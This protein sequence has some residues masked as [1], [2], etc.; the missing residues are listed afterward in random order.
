MLDGTGIMQGM[1]VT[2]LLRL[3]DRTGTGESR[4]RRAHFSQGD[5]T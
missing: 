3:Y 2:L 5:E 1:T 4:I